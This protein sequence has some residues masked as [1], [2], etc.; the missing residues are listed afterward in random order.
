MSRVA[1]VA[2][3]LFDELTARLDEI[4]HPPGWMSRTTSTV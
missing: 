4:T 2:R 1:D 3:V